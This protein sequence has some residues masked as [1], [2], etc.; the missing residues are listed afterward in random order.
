MRSSA[1]WSVLALALPGCFASPHDVALAHGEL[2]NAPGEVD[3]SCHVD[4]GP[5]GATDGQIIA[6][7]RD[8]I[9]CCGVAECTD[10]LLCGDKLGEFV[11]SCAVCDYFEC[12]PGS[13]LALDPTGGEPPSPVFDPRAVA[14][15]AELAVERPR[16]TVSVAS[17]DRVLIE[18]VDRTMERDLSG[19]TSD[20][21]EGQ[22]CDVLDVPLTDGVFR[23]GACCGELACTDLRT[24]RL[25]RPQ[26]VCVACDRE[27]CLTTSVQPRR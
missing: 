26:Q 17:V 13:G 21:A 16:S 12:I 9:W 23:S 24:C 8:G 20:D 7:T 3:G 19:R 22:R 2:D 10:R 27:V 25:S 5:G 11:E 18:T 1:L 4:T 15:L 6:G 14:E